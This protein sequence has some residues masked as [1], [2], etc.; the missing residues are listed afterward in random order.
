MRG[1]HYVFRLLLLLRIEYGFFV[2][3]EAEHTTLHIN[4]E[5]DASQ[6]HDLS[7]VSR[8]NNPTIVG[9]IVKGHAFFA[10]QKNHWEVTNVRY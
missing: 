1:L 7:A 4:F 10:Q 3:Y 9:S 2:I 8:R 6:L 5:H